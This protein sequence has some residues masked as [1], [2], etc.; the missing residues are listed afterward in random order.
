MRCYSGRSHS[1]AAAFTIIAGNVNFGFSIGPYNFAAISLRE[2]QNIGF[3]SLKT[4][5]RLSLALA[6]DA[7]IRSEFFAHKTIIRFCRF[8]PNGRS[9]RCDGLIVIRHQ[10][11][12]DGLARS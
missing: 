3:L 7:N 5:A 6:A 1:Q 11:R 4:K 9:T 12:G 10:R 2:G 8:I